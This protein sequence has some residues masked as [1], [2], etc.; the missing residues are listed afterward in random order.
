MASLPN[1]LPQLAADLTGGSLGLRLPPGKVIDRTENGPWHEPLLWIADS[2]AQQDSWREVM[3]ARRRGLLPVL[4][5]EKYGDLAPRLMPELMSY[6]GDHDAEDVLSEFWEA[7]AA[8]ELDEDNPLPW[9]GLAL[10]SLTPDGESDCDPD[11]NADELASSVTGPGEDGFWLKAPRIALVPA[12]RSADIPAAIGWTGPLNHEN[13][14]ARL[15]AVLRSW[16]DR[17]GARLVALGF[18][19]MLVSVAAP[20]ATRAAAE[21]LAAE[22]YAFCPDN[23]DQAGRTTQSSYAE[24]LLQERSWAFWWD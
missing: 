7:Y 14:V 24:S 19:T 13:D 21:L 22:H 5:G 10:S 20:P 8:E 1:P 16:E 18:D 6:P 15:C 12:R 3:A 11:A 4:I 9:P 2:R 17:F 23:I